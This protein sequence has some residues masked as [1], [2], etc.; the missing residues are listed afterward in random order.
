MNMVWDASIYTGKKPSP[1]ENKIYLA[2]TLKQ[3]NLIETD[4]ALANFNIS[5]KH[6]G[7]TMGSGGIKNIRCPVAFTCAELDVVIPPA[8]SRE[9]AAAISGS[10]L[11]EYEKCGHSPLVDCPDRLATDIL[12]HAGIC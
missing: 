11:F 8:T 12:T 6:N 1:E 3:R 5:D 10:K 4:W 7:Y 2:E 9:N